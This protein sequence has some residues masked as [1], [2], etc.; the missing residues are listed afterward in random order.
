MKTKGFLSLVVISL[1]LSL[2][3]FACSSDSDPSG[4]NDSDSS[5]SAGYQD[6]QVFCQL[7]T[8]ACSQLSL[9]VCMELVTA[10]MAQIV[11]NC[12]GL[13]SSSMDLVL[14]SSSFGNISLSSS[15]IIIVISSS[16]FN[17]VVQSSSSL[18]PSSSGTETSSSSSVYAC[19]NLNHATEFCFDDTVY[20][21]CGWVS[22]YNPTS[23]NCCGTGKY[24]T[25]TQFCDKRDNKV[26]KWVEIGEQIWM[27]ENLNYIASG[28]KC[29]GDGNSST[30]A[31][32]SE[33]C[34][35][36]GRLYNWATAMGI[37]ES[38]NSSVYGT[39]CGSNCYD[40]ADIPHQGICPNGWHIPTDAEWTTLT[41]NTGGSSVGSITGNNLKATSGWGGISYNGTDIYGFAALPGGYGSGNNSSYVGRYGYW[42]S[43][44]EASAGSTYFRSIYDDYAYVNRSNSNKTSLYSIRCIQN[45]AP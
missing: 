28:S 25:A 1:A 19:A 24:M 26:Y 14:S 31:D 4:P 18:V 15:S 34:D 27:A 35:I 40:P 16:S 8:G 12:D 3:F 13:S 23:E 7:T 45:S 33:R 39:S 5:S 36:Y 20:E 30:L 38:Y 22:E 6:T 2:I 21:K 9:S 11:P 10:G 37:S 43:A 17:S 32:Y 42:Q 41:N 44:T 29:V